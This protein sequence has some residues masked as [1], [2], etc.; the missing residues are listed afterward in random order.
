[1]RTR[2]PRGGLEPSTM[3]PGSI[4]TWGG[5]MAACRCSSR[6]RRRWRARCAGLGP[7]GPLQALAGP[8][9]DEPRASALVGGYLADELPRAAGDGREQ[10]EVAWSLGDLFEAAGLPEQR[11]PV[12]GRADPRDPLGRGAGSRS[13]PARARRVLGSRRW[14]ASGRARC[15]RPGPRCR[16]PSATGAARRGRRRA[17]RDRRRASCRRAT[18]L[19]LDDRF[20]W[21][22]EFPWMRPDARGRRPAAALPARAPGGPG[23]AGAATASRSSGHR[24]GP[25]VT[26]DTTRLW[27]AVVE[28]APRWPRSSSA[29][30]SA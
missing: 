26:G 23:A 22:E 12:P 4:T 5:R 15:R 11:G 25:R 20:R 10:H 30:R 2:P 21:T 18:V 9:A 7:D 1:M 13:F 6:R 29:T 24:P 19:A 3:A 28:P 14:P 8:R 17:E 27:R 16:W